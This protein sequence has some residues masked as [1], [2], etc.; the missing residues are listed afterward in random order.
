MPGIPVTDTAGRLLR[1]ADCPD[2]IHSEVFIRIATEVPL[3]QQEKSP[4][5]IKSPTV[6]GVIGIEILKPEMHK[7]PC[8]LDQ[9]LVEGIVGMFPPLPEPE[10]FEHV[11]GL[12]VAAPVEAGEISSQ[13]GSLEVSTGPRVQRVQELRDA[14]RLES[15]LHLFGMIGIHHAMITPRDAGCNR[16]IRRRR[17]P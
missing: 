3:G 8:K 4:G 16:G 12:V 10:L 9:P 7:S 5:G 11:V 14:I 15:V 1:Q 13:A 2:D 6:L 17:R